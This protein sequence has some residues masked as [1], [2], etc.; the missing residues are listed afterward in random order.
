MSLSE[1]VPR[2]APAYGVATQSRPIMASPSTQSLPPM[3]AGVPTM[4][5]VPAMAVAATASGPITTAVQG[6]TTSS[7]SPLPSTGVP[8]G[9]TGVRPL[10]T[11]GVVSIDRQQASQF[12]PDDALKAPPRLTSGIPDPSA[13]AQQREAYLRALEEQE[14]QAINVLEQQRQQQVNLLR[15]QGDQQ[16]KKFF[17]EVNQQVS[18]NDIV[19]TQQHSEQMMVL[20]QQYSQQRGLLENQA[21]TLIMEYQQKKAHEDMMLQQYKLQLDQFT[22]QQKYNEEMVRLQN[23]QERVQG[24]LAQAYATS[25]MPPPMKR[26]TTYVPSITRVNN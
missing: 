15:A 18:Q 16:K 11:S 25:Y 20:N 23:Q 19:M 5:Q 1:A 7:Y 21:N 22:A 10:P 6:A 9:V 12:Q 2:S 24:A 3:P 13:I 4:T 26:Q 8:A 14:R 17:L